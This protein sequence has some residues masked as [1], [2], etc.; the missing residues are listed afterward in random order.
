YLRLWEE[1]SHSKAMVFLSGPRQVGKTTMAKAIAATFPSSLYFNW[2]IRD[3]RARLLRDPSFFT[4]LDNRG[5]GRAL[6]VFDE[7]HKYRQWK[8]HLKGAYDGH[9]GQF[10][11][12][13]LGSGR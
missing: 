3:D 12:L 8:N 7:I 13:V 10:Q 4:K 6:V 11:F 2:D 5:P 9:S 1:L